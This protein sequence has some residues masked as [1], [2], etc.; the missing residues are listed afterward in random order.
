MPGVYV[1]FTAASLTEICLF[2]GTE[3]LT[4][5]LVFLEGI[6]A[7][8]VSSTINAIPVQF[9]GSIRTELLC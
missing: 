4:T 9:T 1:S 5:C 3:K 6:N 8:E 2:E 7:F